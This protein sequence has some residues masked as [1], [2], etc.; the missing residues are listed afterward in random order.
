MSATLYTRELVAAAAN[1]CH[2]TSVSRDLVLFGA[3][4]D[5]SSE[6][7][8]ETFGRPRAPRGGRSTMAPSWVTPVAG[9][10]GVA[11]L[12]AGYIYGM[13]T[14]LNGSFCTPAR[15]RVVVWTNTCRARCFRLPCA[16]SFFIRMLETHL[17]A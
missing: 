13:I 9:V 6:L 5:G 14:L 4:L 11:M 7:K 17:A 2:R 3:V 8:F 16:T 12:Y 10:A 15:D 1:F